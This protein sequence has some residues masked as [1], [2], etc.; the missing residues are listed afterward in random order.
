MLASV[1]V[2]DISISFPSHSS[3]KA[4]GVLCPG[5]RN[6]LRQS[7]CSPQ[8]SNQSS[9]AK[10]VCFTDPLTASIMLKAFLRWLFLAWEGLYSLC[11]HC[12]QVYV[13]SG[14][15]RIWPL[16]GSTY[17]QNVIWCN[18]GN[19]SFNFSPFLSRRFL[20]TEGKFENKAETTKFFTEGV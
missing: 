16:E 1:L 5:S 9:R 12:L 14:Q 11:Q 15:F 8:T 4:R 20:W 3:L 17:S 13:S 7:R 19:H 2:F 18:W 6:L 10:R